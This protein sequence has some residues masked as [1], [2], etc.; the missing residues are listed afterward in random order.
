MVEE[1]SLKML[2]E[3]RESIKDCSDRGLTMA[4]KWYVISLEK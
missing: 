2:L 1:I 4:S 3:I